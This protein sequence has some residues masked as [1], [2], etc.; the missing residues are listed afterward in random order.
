M[1]V[2]YETKLTEIPKNCFDCQCDWC[3]LPC[4]KNTFN[5]IFK[6]K[7]KEQRHQA[8]PLKVKD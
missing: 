5:P 3:K 6:N 1:K 7:Y 4:T 2:Y 8:C